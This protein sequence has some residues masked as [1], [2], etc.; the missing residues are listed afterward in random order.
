MIVLGVLSL[1]LMDGEHF[2]LETWIDGHAG[3]HHG[4]QMLCFVPDSIHPSYIFQFSFHVHRMRTV[5][6]YCI[7]MQFSQDIR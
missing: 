1:C 6:R 2:H 4:I 5:S 3:N 7:H